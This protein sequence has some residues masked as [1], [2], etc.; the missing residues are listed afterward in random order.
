MKTSTSD[1]VLM[2]SC[3]ENPFNMHINLD[4]WK[5][6]YLRLKVTMEVK[7]LS[8]R[9]DSVLG[10]S[11]YLSVCRSCFWNWKQSLF[12]NRR[13]R[14]REIEQPCA[15]VI[16]VSHQQQTISQ[17][18]QQHQHQQ[19]VNSFTKIE[20][21]RVCVYFIFIETNSNRRKKMEKKVDL[22]CILSNKI[23]KSPSLSRCVCMLF[24]FFFCLHIISN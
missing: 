8:A 23:H 10:R 14:E 7:M 1:E 6:Q 5:C 22:S 19:R 24:F 12:T 9:Q 11:N 16:L 15:S 21:R 17:S 18:E 13:E 20:S 2:S 3:S 4:E